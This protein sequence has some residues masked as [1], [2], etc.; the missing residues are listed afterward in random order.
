MVHGARGRPRDRDENPRR[1]SQPAP[2][3]D[4]HRSGL[5]DVGTRVS[6]VSVNEAAGK[7]LEQDSLIDTLS[8]EFAIYLESYRQVEISWRGQKLN[9]AA[10]QV[11]RE[12][13]DLEV[14]GLDDRPQ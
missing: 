9:P 12:E 5:G 7:Q 4:H 6:V 3:R 14:D 1:A 10:L 13:Y 2:L 11:E 8:A